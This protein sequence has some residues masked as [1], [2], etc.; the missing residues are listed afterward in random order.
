MGIPRT[1]IV[2]AALAVVTGLFVNKLYLF[3]YWDFLPPLVYDLDRG[4]AYI[5]STVGEVEHFQNVFYAEEPSG[6]LRF[7]P[8][9][10]LRHPKGALIN[11][12]AAGAW[13]PQGLGDVLPFTSQV[14]DISENCLSLRIARLKGTD[15]EQKLPVVVYLHG[16]VYSIP[17]AL[18]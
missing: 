3:K 12:T 14:T 18:S 10:S 7:A 4:I 5:G 1:A 9:V 6:P 17:E 16:G 8:P 13:C 15:R 11:A 2:V